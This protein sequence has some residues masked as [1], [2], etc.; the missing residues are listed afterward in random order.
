MKIIIYCKGK[1]FEKYKQQLPWEQIVAI[2]DKITENNEIICNKPVIKPEN[3]KTLQY[4]YIVVFSNDYFYE[5]VKELIYKHNV[6]PERIVSW[7]ALLKKCIPINS[8]ILKTLVN[9]LK[10]NNVLIRE[11]EMFDKYVLNRESIGVPSDSLFETCSKY[12]K[13][14][15]SYKY[16]CVY[17]KNQIP[18]NKKYDIVITSDYKNISSILKMK[19]WNK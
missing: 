14:K 1:L 12:Y 7:K 9:G 13:K 18:I 8:N 19:N 6:L 17:S 4:D 11:M 5:I 16:D 3:I 15:N 10:H 2:S